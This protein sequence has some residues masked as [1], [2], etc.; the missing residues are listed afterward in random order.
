MY[1]YHMEMSDVVVPAAVIT[2]VV[3]VGRPPGHY[4]TGRLTRPQAGV[5]SAWRARLLLDK[6]LPGQPSARLAA[7]LVGGS[8]RPRA[9]CSDAVAAAAADLLRQPPGPLELARYAYASMQAASDAAHGGADADEAPL[10]PPVSWYLPAPLAARAEQLRADAC[11]AVRAA[12]D[13]AL[14]EAAR[15]YPGRTRPGALARDLHAA[16]KLARAGLPYSRQVPR[17]TIAR[18]AIDRWARRHPDDVAADAVAYAAAVHQQPHR[19]R[20]DMRRLTR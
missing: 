16:G 19:A 5:V 15:I 9:S 6:P 2:G 20:R 12:R 17:G 10:Y 7:R 13:E 8:D 11:A 1:A 18:M 3:V 14:A 4:S